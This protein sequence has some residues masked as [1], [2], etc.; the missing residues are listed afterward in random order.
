MRPGHLYRV[1]IPCFWDVGEQNVIKEV[2]TVFTFLKKDVRGQKFTCLFEDGVYVSD[3][4]LYGQF[5]L[6][7]EEVV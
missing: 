2:G 5:E 1:K 6:F 7:F 3:E 4:V